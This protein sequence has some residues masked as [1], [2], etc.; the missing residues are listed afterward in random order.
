MS[1]TLKTG[2]DL[3]EVPSGALGQ[4][5]TT[6]QRKAFALGLVSGGI[7]SAWLVKKAAKAA[8]L[9]LAGAGAYV[10]YYVWSAQ[11]DGLSA[12]LP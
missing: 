11:T 8:T 10:A 9:A 2:S 6:S 12:R 3:L 1:E 5:V 7:L 4:A